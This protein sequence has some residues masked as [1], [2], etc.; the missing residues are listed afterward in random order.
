MGL[1]KVL[2]F[3]G[4][5]V[6]EPCGPPLDNDQLIFLASYFSFLLHPTKPH[7]P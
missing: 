2:I 6:W 3:F 5:Q 7:H 4:L 1:E